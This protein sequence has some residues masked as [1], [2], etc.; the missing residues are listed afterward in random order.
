LLVLAS[1]S[2][3]RRE[4]LARLNLDFTVRVSAAPEIEQGDPAAVTVENAL[5]KAR[6]VAGAPDGPPETIIGCDTVVALDGRLFGKPADEREATATIRALG[7]RTQQVVSGLAVLIAGQERT[8][9]TVT[10]VTFKPID[11]Q[12]L[13]SY[14]ATG[15]WRERSGGYAIQG[16]GAKLVAEVRGDV[17]NVVGLPLGTLLE[18][19]PEL[20]PGG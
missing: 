16:A 6:A 13:A 7:G 19:C 10:E 9:V 12:Q 5:R 4:I 15:E 18:I 2:P 20:S 11:E 14:V 17:D 3:Q 1:R 8:A